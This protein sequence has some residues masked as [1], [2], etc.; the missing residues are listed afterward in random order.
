MIRTKYNI[1]ISPK[2]KC[3][4]SWLEDIMQAMNVEIVRDWSQEVIGPAAGK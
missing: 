1:D 3:L 4:V 2:M